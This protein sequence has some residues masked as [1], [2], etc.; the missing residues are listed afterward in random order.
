MATA[1]GA[2]TKDTATNTFTGVLM[3]HLVD[4]NGGTKNG[5]YGFK[6]G[7]STFGL[8]AHTGN[9]YFAGHVDALSGTIGGWEI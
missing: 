5:L 2:G 9:A 7:V 3:G 1:M 4:T 8:D 6:N